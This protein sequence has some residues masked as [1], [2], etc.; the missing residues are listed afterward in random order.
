[1]ICTNT[2]QLSSISGQVLNALKIYSAREMAVMK[3]IQKQ[4]IKRNDPCPVAM[5]TSLWDGSTFT[6]VNV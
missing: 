2:Q 3:T 5:L 6:C 1:M 4:W